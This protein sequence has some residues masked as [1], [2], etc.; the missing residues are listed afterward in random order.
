MSRTFMMFAAASLL[1]VTGAVAGPDHSAGNDGDAVA[2][3]EQ[4]A[5]RSGPLLVM[6]MMNSS[7]GRKLYAAKGCV[8]CHSIN[9]VGGED[10]PDLNAHSMDQY[11]NPFDLA[12]RMWRGAATMILMQEEIFGEQIEF[13]GE[14]LAD[15]IAFLHDDAEQHKFSEA[16]IPQN[17]MPMMSH[18]HGDSSGVEDH[19]EELGHHAESDEDDDHNN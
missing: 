19:A 2:N 3:H 11:M 1:A 17:I 8:A 14:E 18:M 15:I 10:A 12:A 9:G 4:E 16:D 5:S 13:T 7:R 6:P